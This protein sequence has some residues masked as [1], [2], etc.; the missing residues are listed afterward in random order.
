MTGILIK[1][2]QSC[3]DMERRPRVTKAEIGATRPPAE[4]CQRTNGSPSLW[5]RHCPARPLPPGF[6]PRTCKTRSS[7]K[8]PRVWYFVT[9]APGDNR[10]E[11]EGKRRK[12]QGSAVE[13]H[14]TPRSGGAEER[15]GRRGGGG[16]CSLAA[17]GTR[18]V[19]GRLAPP[20]SSSVKWDNSPHA[21][22]FEE[23]MC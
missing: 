23:P 19:A 18:R 4:E 2:G 20:A 9:A 13:N 15:G 1:E 11:K 14:T 6:A 21:P 16:P 3:R 22:G 8:S 12:V 7:A 5:R 10:G 17:G